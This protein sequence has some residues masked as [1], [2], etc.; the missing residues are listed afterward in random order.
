M[1]EAYSPMHLQRRLRFPSG[2]NPTERRGRTIGTLMGKTIRHVQYDFEL[3][4]FKKPFH[5][6]ISFYI[7]HYLSLSLYIVNYIH[8]CVWYICYI[9]IYIDIDI[10]LILQTSS[11]PRSSSGGHSLGGCVSATTWTICVL[12]P[13]RDPRRG[14]LIRSLSRVPLV[15]SGN[16]LH[17][18]WTWPLIDSGFTQLENGSYMNV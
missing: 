5:L 15:A 9:H 14:F 10:P 2:A 12:R 8:I 16:L 3:P 17:S 4:H 11:L 18:Y 1:P 13:R 6:Y 7:Y